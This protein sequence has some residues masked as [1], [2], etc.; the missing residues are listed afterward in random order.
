[1]R[2]SFTEWKHTIANKGLC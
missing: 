2:I 1:M